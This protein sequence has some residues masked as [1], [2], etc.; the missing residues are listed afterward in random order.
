VIAMWYGQLSLKISGTM[1][2]GTAISMKSLPRQA[3][4]LVNQIT[5][6]HDLPQIVTHP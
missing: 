1:N 5:A 2:F 4:D 3:Q 6:L